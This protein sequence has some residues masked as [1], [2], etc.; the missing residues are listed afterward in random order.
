MPSNRPETLPFRLIIA[1]SILFSL[2]VLGM[3][4]AAFAPPESELTNFF[5][6]YALKLLGGEVLAIVGFVI[7][8]M[9]SDRP[10]EPTDGSRS[11][12]N[13]TPDSSDPE[14]LTQF[15]SND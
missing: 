10:S 6:R 14:S 3:V 2:T 1:S 8:A 5:D 9:V 12:D 15:G 11:P 13:R 4:A 7:L